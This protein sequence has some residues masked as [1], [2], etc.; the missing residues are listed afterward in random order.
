MSVMIGIKPSPGDN[1]SNFKKVG[2]IP[3]G[4]NTENLYYVKVIG[5]SMALTALLTLLIP[6][7]A[8]VRTRYLHVKAF[9]D[10]LFV[11]NLNIFL[12]SSNYFNIKSKYFQVFY[13]ENIV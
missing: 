6:I 13:V 1:E 7:A 11:S 5:L 12:L 3:C 9:K 8:K 4:F 2:S 10:L